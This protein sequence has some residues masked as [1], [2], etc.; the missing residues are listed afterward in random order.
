[1]CVC[2]CVGVDV[3]DTLTVDPALILIVI[4]SVMFFM[5]I[6]GCLGALRNATCLLRT[7]RLNPNDHDM[8]QPKRSRYDSTQTITIRLKPN[9]Y[10][11]TQP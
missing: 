8:T 7:V 6:F 4:G 3:I 9:D 5:N 10:D 1:M 11:T 2:V